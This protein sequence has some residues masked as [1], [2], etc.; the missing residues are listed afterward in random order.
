MVINMIYM[1]NINTEIFLR[2]VQD[3]N[4]LKL[5]VEVN[6]WDRP[7]FSA[8]A[9][10]LGVDRRTV[11]KYYEDVYK[12]QGIGSALINISIEWAKHKNSHGLMLETQDNNLIA[13]KFYHNCGFKIG[14]VDTCLLYTSR[15]V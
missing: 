14:S 13:C 7:N 15:C 8:I 10:E 1:I 9:R 11:K 4:K 6:N 12:R 5:L 3:L 2:S